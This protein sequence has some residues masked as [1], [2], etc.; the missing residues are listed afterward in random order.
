MFKI[1]NLIFTCLCIATVL[2]EILGVGLLWQRGQLNMQTLHDIRLI[3]SGEKQDAEVESEDQD[4]PQMSLEELVQA[5]AKVDADLENRQRELNT[6]EQMIREKA[7]QI[8][9]KQKKLEEN[10]TLFLAELEELRKKNLDSATEQGR[11]ILMALPPEEA[12][13]KLLQA[14]LEEDLILLQGMS[15]KIIA[16]ILQEMK[17]GEAAKRGK[18]IFHSLAT[19]RLTSL[20]IDQAAEKSAAPGTKKPT[21]PM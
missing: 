16:N 15:E 3:L 2:S 21:P 6:F 18:E 8:S 19:G 13:Q 17:E 10:R 5:R 1:I 4:A 7:D 9:D 14:T 11:G 12:A 20:P